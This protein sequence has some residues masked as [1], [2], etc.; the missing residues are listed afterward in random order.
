MYSETPLRAVSG[1]ASR[2][3]CRHAGPHLP[4]LTAGY[5][6]RT[7]YRD[8][9]HAASALSALGA[10]TAVLDGGRATAVLTCAVDPY[11]PADVTWPRARPDATITG[12]GAKT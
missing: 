7:F 12:P 4:F 5:S 9:E 10:Q 3:Y 11:T 1:V 2:P 6:L 8:D